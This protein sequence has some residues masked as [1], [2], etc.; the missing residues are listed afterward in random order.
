[1]TIGEF[2]GNETGQPAKR[3]AG[4]PRKNIETSVQSGTSVAS[5]SDAGKL[6]DRQRAILR[7]IIQEFT[8]TAAPVSSEAIVNKYRLPYSSATVR[9]EMAELEQGGYISHPHTSAGRVPSDLG[10]RYFVEHLMERSGGLSS[11]EQTTIQHQFYQIQLE[12]TEWLRLAASVTARTSHNA[13]LVSTP[14]VYDNRLKHVQLVGVQERVA[15]LV[16]VTQ[17]GTIKEQM[18]TLDEP[19][20]QNELTQVTNRLNTLLSNLNWVKMEARI[21]DWPDDFNKMIAN[22]MLE[23]FKSLDRYKDAQIYRDGLVNILDQPEFTDIG[24][25][26]QVVQVIENGQVITNIIP[27]ILSSDGNAVQVIIGGDN[28]FDDLRLLSVVL[29][30]YGIDGQMAGVVGI[31]GPTRMEYNRSISTVQYIANL[32][33]GLVSERRG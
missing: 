28:R 32:L 10:Y 22:R 27:E 30:R 31:V 15:L 4:R 13:A 6:S 19:V 14:R 16:V 26:R 8:A 18:L 21:K 33:S 1:M 5:N 2:E 11:I 3:K 7:I 25:V 12:L 24:R 9:N 23:T 20:T 17:D 29:A